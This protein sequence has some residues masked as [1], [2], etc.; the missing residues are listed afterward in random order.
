MTLQFDGE[1][2]V[3]GQSPPYLNWAHAARYQFA[4]E[5]VAGRTVLDAGCGAGYGS[6]YLAQF[7]RSVVGIDISP[8]AV[9]HAADTYR[10]EN[11][12]YRVQ[13]CEVDLG[14][15][16][17]TVD[18]ICAFEMIEHLRSPARFL[19][20]V[21][22]TLRPGGLFIVSTPNTESSFP[23]GLDPFHVQ[24]Y[25]PAGFLVLL[26]PYFDTVESYGQVCLKPFRERLYMQSTSV[27]LKSAMYRR[28]VNWLAP[29]YLRNQDGRDGSCDPAWVDRAC[30]GEF[31]F[32]PGS[33]VGATYLLALCRT[34]KPYAAIARDGEGALTGFRD[35]GLGIRDL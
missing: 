14:A 25:N 17:H 3:P 6:A 13:D 16:D 1:R 15:E 22:R 18:V 30:T 31:T 23:S 35:L 11:L 32:R 19:R 21:Q 24:E 29:L 26:E 20:A 4:R 28:F 12:C 34:K 9:R 10:A 5:W 27:Y 33:T 7:A 8:E 2:L